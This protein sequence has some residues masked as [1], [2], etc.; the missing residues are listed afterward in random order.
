MAKKSSPV[1]KAV[2]PKSKK[3]LKVSKSQS[4]PIKKIAGGYK[5][6][7][8]TGGSQTVERLQAQLAQRNAELAIINSIQQGLASKLEIQAIYDLVGEKIREIFKNQAQTVFFTFYDPAT[9]LSN[10]P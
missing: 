4:A 10:F 3:E 8:S 9:D 7:K 6:V 2:N 5:S 1:R